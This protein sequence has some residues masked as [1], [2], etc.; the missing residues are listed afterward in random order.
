MKS[1]KTYFK[2]ENISAVFLLFNFSYFASQAIKTI[3]NPTPPLTFSLYLVGALIEFIFI[4]F[5][6]L[7]LIRSDKNFYKILLCRF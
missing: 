1:I 3:N 6:T 4:Y 7:T 5:L 2:K